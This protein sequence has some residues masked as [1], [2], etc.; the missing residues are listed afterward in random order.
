MPLTLSRLD[1]ATEFAVIEMGAGKPGDIAVL[2]QMVKPDI[3]VL[4]TVVPAHIEHYGH[5]D[6]IA[7]TKAAILDGLSTEG[8]AVINGDLP[9][10][11]QW[12]QR[13]APRTGNNLWVFQG[14][15]LPGKTYSASTAS[16]DRSAK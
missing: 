16:L 3:S 14:G 8:L 11:D 6:A 2:Q 13:A 15:R 9:W 5:L 10:A 7:D 4:L 12:R 1:A